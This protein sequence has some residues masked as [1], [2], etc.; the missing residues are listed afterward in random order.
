MPKISVII[1]IFN[2]E[3]FLAMAIKSCLSQSLKECEIILV[4]D[5]SIDSSLQIAR[6]FAIKDSRIKIIENPRNLGTFLARKRGVEI[7]NGKF[8]LFLDADDYLLPNAFEIL[9]DLA[10][11]NCADMVHFG[12]QTKPI[13][14]FATKPK[15]HIKALENDAILGE[16]FVRYFKKSYLTLFGRLFSANLVR[17]AL[18]KLNFINCHLSNSEDS[19]LFF[20]LC[21]LA[22]KSVG[23]DK[24]LYIYTQNPH[25]FLKS[26]IPQRIHKQVADRTFIRDIFCKN[27]EHLNN[28]STLSK[29]RFFRQSMQN[30]CNLMDYFICYSMRFL[31]RKDADS[32][33]SPYIKYSILS[34]KYV[35]RW[36]IMIKLAI[37]MLTLGRKKL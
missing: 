3:S 6:G 14:R 25:S 24:I 15:I 30:L 23:V 29:N 9:Y 37:F 17:I 4:D 22:K 1:P 35:A 28:D 31:S 26:K 21:A 36:Q 33:I 20:M 7:A 2:A 12:F 32:I 8:I 5:K 34:L 11:K 10:I 18:Q 19:A 13:L 16:I 27:W